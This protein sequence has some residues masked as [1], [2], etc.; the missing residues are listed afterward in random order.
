MVR[1]DNKISSILIKFLIQCF[2]GRREKSPD[3]P[4]TKPHEDEKPTDEEKGGLFKRVSIFVATCW[5]QQ[6]DIDLIMISC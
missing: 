5:L 6:H 2:A 1:E 3:E 4:S